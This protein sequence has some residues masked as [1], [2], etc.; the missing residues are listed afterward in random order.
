MIGIIFV[1]RVNDR[2]ISVN[3]ISLEYVDHATAIS[4]LRDCGNKV[5]LVSTTTKYKEVL[6]FVCLLVCLLVCFLDVG[7]IMADYTSESNVFW[8]GFFFCQIIHQSHFCFFF[9]I[10]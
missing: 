8:M 3:S 9:I 7:G 4:V 2:I 5:H 1:C 10:D 6:L